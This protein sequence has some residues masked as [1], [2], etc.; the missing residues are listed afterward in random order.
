M[1]DEVLA[2]AKEYK[3]IMKLVMEISPLS[4][5][6]MY[7]HAKVKRMEWKKALCKAR[8]TAPAPSIL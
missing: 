7:L 4:K 3:R 5:R 1:A 6:I 2:W 8:K